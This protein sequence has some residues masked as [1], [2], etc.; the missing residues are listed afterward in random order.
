MINNNILVYAN[1]VYIHYHVYI[2]Y[3]YSLRTI[4]LFY[5]HIF[6]LYTR[7]Y[8]CGVCIYIFGDYRALSDKA[9]KIDTPRLF[10]IIFCGFQEK[11][12][13]FSKMCL[14]DILPCFETSV[15][16]DFPH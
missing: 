12:V 15:L 5:I 14:S 4:G 3:I 11:I 6:I 1:I 13:H 10:H 9:N 16:P 2:I 8:V 7:V